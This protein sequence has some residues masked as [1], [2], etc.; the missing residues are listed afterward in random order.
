MISILKS[1]TFKGILIAAGLI[2]GIFFLLQKNECDCKKRIS[3]ENNHIND[4]IS[5][6]KLFAP[7]DSLELKSILTAWEKF[8]PKSD[9]FQ[10][11]R[12]VPYT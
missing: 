11:I 1:P 2:S 8:N 5:L 12:E 10:I 7:T 6:E 9:D 4:D 3:Y